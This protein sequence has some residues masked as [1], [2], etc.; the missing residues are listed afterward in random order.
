[1]S[2]IKERRSNIERRQAA[3]VNYFPILDADGNF[4]ENDR[5]SGEDRRVDPRNTLQFM[6]AND[7]LAR[8]GDL[9]SEG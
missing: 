6:N 4:I 2:E 3:P 8:F 1:M 7:L 5:R 9:D